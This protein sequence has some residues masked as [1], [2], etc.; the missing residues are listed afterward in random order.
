[1]ETPLLAFDAALQ[2]VMKSVPAPRKESV[3]LRQSRG[4]I[5][6]RDVRSDRDLP[7]FDRAAL[8]GYAVRTSRPFGERRVLP[9]ITEIAAG[10]RGPRSL[11][12]DTCVRVWTGAAVPAG[13]QG[14]IPVE[15]AREEEGRVVLEGPL[16]TSGRRRPGIADRAEDARRGTR[17]LERGREITVGDL[18]VLG[19]VGVASVPV[20]REPELAILVTGHELVSPAERP[21]PVQI[22]STNDLVVE[23]IGSAV[24]VRRI[25]SLGTVEDKAGPLRRALRRGFASDVLVVTGGIS[26]GRLDLVPGLLRELGVRIRLHRVAIR[27]GKP[28][29]FGTYSTEGHRTAV[30]GLPGNP[31]STMVTALV[32]LAPFLRAWR[33]ES[34]PDRHVLAARISTAIRRGKGLLHFVPCDVGV[35]REGILRARDIPMHGSGDYVSASRARG[36]L[37]VPGDGIERE[38]GTVLGLDLLPEILPKGERS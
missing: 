24:G 15:R 27:P 37:R 4:R 12:P 23:A 18:A 19:G 35:D 1:M 34:D 25:R 3:P 6:A 32:F 14:I 22:R 8:D 36:L 13:A 38:A 7:P 26:M 33:G 17:L 10:D 30:F 20:I 11:R 16:E 31:V 28:F 5:L 29:L 2:I 9:V 21:A